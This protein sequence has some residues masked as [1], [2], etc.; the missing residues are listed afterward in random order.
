[1]SVSKK[2]NGL[3][4]L[5]KFAHKAVSEISDVRAD[6]A[7]GKLGS[8]QATANIGLFNASARVLNTAI[9]AERWEAQK[10]GNKPAKK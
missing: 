7:A 4:D 2:E 9:Q 10:Q 5:V 6:F 8:D 3:V 1:M